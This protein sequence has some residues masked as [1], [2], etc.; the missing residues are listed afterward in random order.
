[1][2]RIIHINE[3]GRPKDYS[4]RTPVITR[5]TT[6]GN[7]LDVSERGPRGIL[8][9]L[10]YLHRGAQAGIDK[11]NELEATAVRRPGRIIELNP[12]Y[13]NSQ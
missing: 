13:A 2:A 11:A 1:M 4:A 3:C 9:I 12:P 10:G 6:S 7:R 5:G 8:T